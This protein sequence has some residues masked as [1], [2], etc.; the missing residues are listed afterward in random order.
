M[1]KMLKSELVEVLVEG[2]EVESVYFM[3]KYGL[4]FGVGYDMII[5]IHI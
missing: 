4:S 1:R 3:N 5:N 2:G